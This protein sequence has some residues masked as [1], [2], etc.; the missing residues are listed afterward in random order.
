MTEESICNPQTFPVPKVSGCV[1]ESRRVLSLND[2]ITE[3]TVV[4]TAEGNIYEIGR[5]I[6]DTIFGRVHHAN[7][8]R[9]SAEPDILVRDET[10]GPV[11]IKIFFRDK[12]FKRTPDNQED[13]VKE[14]SVLQY[15]R[16]HEEAGKEYVIK[17]HEVCADPQRIF[18]VMDFIDG[19]ELYDILEASQHLSEGL[20]RF[21]FRQIVRGYQFLHSIGLCHR[22]G[23]LE[24]VLVT[25]DGQCKIID[26]G[27][28]IL[29]KIVPETGRV[30][31][32]SH[33]KVCGKANYIAPEI[34]TG[35]SVAPAIFP[36][37]YDRSDVWALGV[38]LFILI[39]GVP[40]V[41]QAIELDPR[42]RMIQQG[43]LG[44]MLEQWGIHISPEAVDLLKLLLD[45]T[46]SKRIDLGNIHNHFW[47]LL[48]DELP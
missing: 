28:C 11:A 18:I 1:V 7:Y 47:M 13:P 35:Q 37:H 20:A 44:D 10:K 6:K 46:P 9:T 31:A 40:P 45:P 16:N 21:Y 17:C 25:E 8:L 38:M 24:N 27:M 19:G 4:S 3:K 15:I 32:M 42:Y 22:D 26:F 29:S 34:F 2:L 41:D 23:S 43:G 33:Q 30:M 39:T 5:H 12:L 36:V 14:I 48:E